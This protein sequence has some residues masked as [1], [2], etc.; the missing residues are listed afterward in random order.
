MEKMENLKREFIAKAMEAFYEGAF[1][2]K[3]NF[4]SF[5]EELADDVEY[6][7]RNSVENMYMRM[8]YTA[9]KYIPEE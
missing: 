4:R 8:S 2:D 1:I 7:D 5:L 3:S 9:S 6:G